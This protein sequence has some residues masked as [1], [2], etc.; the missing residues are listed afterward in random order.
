[1][2]AGFLFALALLLS[3]PLFMAACDTVSDACQTARTAAD[4]VATRVAPART[5]TP[6]LDPT[7]AGTSSD[8]R[9]ILATLRALEIADREAVIE[10]N[11]RDWRHWIDSDKDCQN[12]RAE[13]LIEESLA[14]VS[15]ATD[16]QCR[17][18]GGRW[19]GPWTGEI[20]T[21]SS[22]VDIDHHVPLGHAHLSGGSAWDDDRKRAYANDM[23]H[24]GSLQVT[25]A[26]VNRS[27]GKNAPDEWRP[28][29][30]A[31][32]CRYAV[33]WISTKH[34]WELTVTDAEISALE[35]MLATCDDADS[36]G[37]S[38]VQPP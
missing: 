32:W 30:R 6:I 33:D 3:A 5:D 7:E 24:A 15:F 27:K 8:V 16:E 10:Y 22:D 37:L 20:F 36:W 14:A 1:M 2:R 11:R 17:V 23:T 26:S 29:Q 9:E 31:G 18:I 13:T 34:R 19:I 35:N 4:T 25:S 21:D 12:T 38:G 28:D